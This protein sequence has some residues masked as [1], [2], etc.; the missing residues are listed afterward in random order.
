MKILDIDGNLNEVILVKY[1][2]LMKLSQ[3]DSIHTAVDELS[4][5]DS[6]R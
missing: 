1:H 4:L 3:V 6:S 2:P 5:T